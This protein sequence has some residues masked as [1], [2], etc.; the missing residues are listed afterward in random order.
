M[1]PALIQRLVAEVFPPYRF[2]EPGTMLDRE[3]AH[4]RTDCRRSERYIR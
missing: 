3:S 1:P 4:G 2:E